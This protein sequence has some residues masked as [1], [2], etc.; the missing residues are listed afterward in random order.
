VTLH[1]PAAGDRTVWFDSK[2]DWWLA[3]VLAIVPAVTVASTVLTIVAGESWLSGL[4]SCL[5]IGV[6]YFGVVL[7][8]RYGISSEELVVRHGLFHHK[9][10]IASITRV[11]A[12]RSALSSPALSL[13]RLRI[14]HG[15]GLFKAVMISPK[16]RAGFLA[17]LSLRAGRSFEAE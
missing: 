6:L 5:L 11:R 12:T 15:T 17:L 14:Q 4:L 8:V 1:P 2:V 13:D 3:V 9:V 10:S 16:D 7:P